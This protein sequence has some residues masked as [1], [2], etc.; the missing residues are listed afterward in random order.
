MI[1]E[2]II[3]MLVCIFILLLACSE[4]DENDSL[5]NRNIMGKDK[6]NVSLSLSLPEMQLEG[7]TDY[8]PMSYGQQGISVLLL[9]ISY[10]CLVIKEIGDKWYV[11]TLTQRKLT[12]A[13]TYAQVSITDDTRFNDLQLTLRPGHYRYW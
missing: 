13:G 10:K 7:N 11:D 12:T 1:K 4:P 9:P 3:G 6:V 5:I 2:K 8:L